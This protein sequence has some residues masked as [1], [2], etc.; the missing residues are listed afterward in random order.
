MA[1]LI[2]HL[3]G[4]LQI[5]RKFIK[6]RQ[7]KDFEYFD[8]AWMER[9]RLMAG[10]IPVETG[11]VIDIGCGKMW[12]KKF[13]PVSC[14][15]YGVDYIYRGESSHIY[16]LNKH[17]FPDDTFD[18]AFVSGCLEYINDYEWLI[19]RIALQSSKC[20]ISYCTFDLFNGIPERT[21][22]GWV[23][24]LT[25]TELTGIFSSHD[26]LL[27]SKDKTTTSNSIYVFSK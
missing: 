21:T 4:L 27:T 7:W 25:E 8:T 3:L 15:Y 14:M 5:K 10:Y 13:I 9:I 23:N 18:I 1:L 20:I 19:K 2:Q 16:D 12:L 11:S 24:H 22:L 26:M 6:N 17:E